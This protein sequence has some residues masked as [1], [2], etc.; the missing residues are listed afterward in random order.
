MNWLLNAPFPTMTKNIVYGSITK[1]K[2][3]VQYS[4]F[5]LRIKKYLNSIASKNTTVKFLIFQISYFFSFYY[6]QKHLLNVA[7]K[8]L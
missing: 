5:K 4:D 8:G 6:F 3:T 2:S 7:R 1:N